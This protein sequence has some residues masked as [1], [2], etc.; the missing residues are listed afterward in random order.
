MN[1]QLISA[2]ELA[3]K[4]LKAYEHNDAIITGVEFHNTENGRSKHRININGSLEVKLYMQYER[5]TPALYSIYISVYDNVW[6]LRTSSFL[7]EVCVEYKNTTVEQTYDYIQLKS[8]INEFVD[9]VYQL[10]VAEVHGF[11]IIP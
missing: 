3:R 2:N 11:V 9:T 6:N 5:M 4:V 8:W 7:N 1:K 10:K